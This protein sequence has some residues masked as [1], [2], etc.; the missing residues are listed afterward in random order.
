MTTPY[1]AYHHECIKEWLL[2]NTQCC[3]CKQTFLYIDTKNGKE[4]ESLDVASLTRQYITAAAL[5]FYSL[6]NG[7]IRIP[8]TILSSRSQLQQLEEQLLSETVPSIDLIASRRNRIYNSNGQIQELEE[9]SQ[10]LED[11]RNNESTASMDLAAPLECETEG[12][13]SDYLE[14][15]YMLQENRCCI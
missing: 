3:L 10:I 8:E 4:K 11:T 12:I 6:P 1:L 2:R 15:S 7:L 14:Q 5:S 9:H 13:E